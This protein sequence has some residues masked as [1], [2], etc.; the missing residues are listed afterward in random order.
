MSQVLAASG[1]E[2]QTS[3]G[4]PAHKMQKVAMATKAAQAATALLVKRLSKHAVLPTRGS[5]GAAGYDLSR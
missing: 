4:E 5:T 2:N 1:Q 3:T